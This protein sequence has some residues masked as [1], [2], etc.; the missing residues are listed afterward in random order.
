[1]HAVTAFTQKV[2][3]A[4]RLFLLKTFRLLS[5]SSSFTQ[6]LHLWL[7]QKC[8]YFTC[9]TLVRNKAFHLRGCG[10]RRYGR[11]RLMW[12][13]VICSEQKMKVESFLCCRPS[14][15][16]SQSRWYDVRSPHGSF[17]AIPQSNSYDQGAWFY[18][19]QPRAGFQKIM[20]Y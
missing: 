12:A 4:V 5:S 6:G 20:I 7:R 13:I 14:A 8:D 19:S 18:L 9:P 10:Q 16:I 15:F 11:V 3:Y 17:A 1:M 2:L